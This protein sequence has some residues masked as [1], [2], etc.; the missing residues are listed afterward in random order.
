LREALDDH[1]AALERFWRLPEI[2]TA[3][4][5]HMTSVEAVCSVTP[6][7]FMAHVHSHSVLVQPEN[8]YSRKH[9][10]YLDQARYSQLFGVALQV[11]YAPVIHISRVRGPDGATDINAVYRA[12]REVCKYVTDFS[13]IVEKSEFGLTADPLV[14]ATLLSAFHKRRPIKTGG[15]FIHAQKIRRER[16][17]AAMEAAHD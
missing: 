14:C 4:L 2:R 1:E 13:K 5:G 15:I 10:L 8:Y 7:G 16:A 12:V 11:D 17:K 3:T 6:G 9:S